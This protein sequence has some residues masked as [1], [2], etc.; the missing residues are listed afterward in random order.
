MTESALL[1]HNLESD[2]EQFYYHMNK[3]TLIAILFTTLALGACKRHR[4]SKPEPAKPTEQTSAD[5]GQ[6]L[7]AVMPID[8]NK[9][10][11]WPGSTDPFQIEDARIE[12]DKL[13]VK[14][15]YGGGCK[16]HGFY[17]HSNLRWAK[18]LPPKTD[19]YLEHVANGDNCRAY[20]EQTLNF[21]LKPMQYP[22]QH[23]VKLTLKNGTDSK[24]LVYKY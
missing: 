2:E 21:D 11:N 9:D 3:Y 17:M 19:L 12:G 14:V 18:S 15:N 7:P 8:V 13:I 24:E 5:A 1:W 16:E 10:Y 4:I 23:E 22:G 20:L 6:R